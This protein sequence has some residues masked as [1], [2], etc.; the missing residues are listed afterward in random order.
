MEKFYFSKDDEVLLDEDWR[1]IENYKKLPYIL[2]HS[3]TNIFPMVKYEEE[4]EHVNDYIYHNQINLNNI[5]NNMKFKVNE[6]KKADITTEYYG[7]NI[8]FRE[9]DEA[10]WEWLIDTITK[11][12]NIVLLLSFIEGALKE[13]YDWFS[14]EKKYI[15]RI[16][17]RGTSNIDYYIKEI[18]SCCN[19]D[20][21]L[22]LEEEL[23]IIRIAKKIRNIFVHEWDAYYNEK[24]RVIL[25]NTLKNFKIINLIDSISKILYFCE[26]AGVEGKILEKEEN[27]IRKFFT[28][29]RIERIK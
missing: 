21:Y 4:L 17:K 24:N 19:Y 8:M 26:Y 18:G 22:K 23:Q 2:F 6:A 20:L 14:E 12:N 7:E 10:T 9:A 11:C 13:I 28:I 3:L 1:I 29:A 5:L 16:K 27:D 15:G 25:D